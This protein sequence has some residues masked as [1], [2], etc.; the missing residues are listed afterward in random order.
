M[1]KYMKS[2]DSEKKNY[3]IFSMSTTDS[4]DNSST[5]FT[6]DE[7]IVK[8]FIQKCNNINE[9]NN[10]IGNNTDTILPDDMTQ[11]KYYQISPEFNLLNNKVK[12][13]LIHKKSP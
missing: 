8:G 1:F 7:T 11:W 6:E 5:E 9:G 4:F 3:H 13:H 2:S 10:G 12:Y